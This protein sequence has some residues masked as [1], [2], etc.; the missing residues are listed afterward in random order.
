[1]EFVIRDIEGNEH[2]PVDQE[3]LVKWV[4]DDRVTAK[5]EVRNSLLGTWKNATDFGFLHEV[6]EAQKSR[7]VAA[8]DNFNKAAKVADKLGSLF[9]KTKK[10]KKTSFVCSY[11]P[12][13]AP[14]SRRMLAFL[15]DLALFALVALILFSYS[16]GIAKRVAVKMTGSEELR[17]ED[18][19]AE[20]DPAWLEGQQADD[21]AETQTGKTEQPANTKSTT[22]KATGKQSTTSPDTT[23]GEGETPPTDEDAEA[24]VVIE[25]PRIP[26]ELSDNL[27]AISP[28]S[29]YADNVNGYN[30]GS[31]WQNTSPGGLRY[32][33][34][35]ANEGAAMWITTTW[36][37]NTVTS[38]F[39]VL[40]VFILLYY[41][42]AV[43]FF[44]QTFGMWYWGIF[45][46][47]KDGDEV[48]FLRA[49][50]WTILLMLLGVLAPLSVYLFRWAPHDLLA[51]V[52][53][54]QVA[55]T[56]PAG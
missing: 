28:P 54:I 34:I 4:E 29:I 47:K 33:C 51:E 15:F 27:K 46:V 12:Q 22:K 45:V 8:E 50:V 6:L 1:M 26:D 9:H 40:L 53:V 14:N 3:T 32:V 39:S 52:K 43:G 44:A 5:T 24:L 18:I 42:I 20:Q 11:V 10:E 49:V 36:L 7:E 30:I 37:R 31:I 25:K 35:S 13:F 2:G 17:E 41:A 55:G 16:V 56:P 19:L 48:Y 38:V 21:A 23:T